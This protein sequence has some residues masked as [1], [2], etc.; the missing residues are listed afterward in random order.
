[1]GRQKFF[2][3]ASAGINRNQ[4]GRWQVMDR[5]RFFF[6]VVNAVGEVVGRFDDKTQH[7][8][9]NCVLV[10]LIAAAKSRLTAK[11]LY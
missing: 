7:N 9:T 11:V 5:E 10:E 2:R 1:M 3:L 8:P 6:S 4:P